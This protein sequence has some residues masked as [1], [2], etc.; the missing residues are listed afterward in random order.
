MKQRVKTWFVNG[1]DTILEFF[2][3]PFIN[4]NARYLIAGFGKTG[5]RNETY[6]SG[7]NDC[8]FHKLKIK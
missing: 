7:P 2:N 3:F 5:S 4:I 1:D 8:Q 6:V